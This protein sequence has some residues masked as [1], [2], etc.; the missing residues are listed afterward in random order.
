VLSA[1]DSHGRQSW[2]SRPEPLL[3]HSSSSSVILTRLSGPDPVPDPLLVRIDYREKI[4]C[5]VIM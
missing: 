4:A 2:F 5:M 1:T 3:F